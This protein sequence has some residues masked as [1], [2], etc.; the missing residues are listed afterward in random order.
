MIPTRSGLRASAIAIVLDEVGVQVWLRCKV[1]AARQAKELVGIFSTWP[2]IFVTVLPLLVTSHRND[3]GP[4]KQADFQRGELL[5][6]GQEPAQV[7]TG[8]RSCTVVTMH[9]LKWKLLRTS[10]YCLSPSASQPTC[11]QTGGDLPLPPTCLERP[12][13]M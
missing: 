9:Y 2:L 12:W 6:L 3:G 1:S 4:A 8:L 7:V 5:S 11:S 10:R 13:S